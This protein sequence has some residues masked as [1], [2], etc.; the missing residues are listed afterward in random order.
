[1]EKETNAA[2]LK[3]LEAMYKNVRMGADSI[4]DIMPKVADEKLREELTSE[5]ERYE[6]FSK[7]IKNSIF[8]MGEEAKDQGILAK[9]GTKM[10]VAMNTMIDST[11]SH[12]AEMM[13]QGGTMGITDATKLLREYE[14]TSCSKEALD[15]ARRIIKYE[16]ETVE[17]L[18]KFL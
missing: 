12:I 11:V 5:L 7:E 6:E 2:T 14:N 4:I 9:V 13:I 3:L 8:N 15:I 16:E 10:S 18:K 17:R 1:M